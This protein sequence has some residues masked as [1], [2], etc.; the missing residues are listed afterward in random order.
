MNGRA[1]RGEFKL[2]LEEAEAS[3]QAAE[4]KASLEAEEAKRAEELA[5]EAE[6]DRPSPVRSDAS[7]E[8]FH[9]SQCI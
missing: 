8:R 5:I 6:I 9:S 3:L 7:S 4:D 2:R 1:S